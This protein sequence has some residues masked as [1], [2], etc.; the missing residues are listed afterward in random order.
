MR[1]LQPV[2]F[3][4]SCGIVGPAELPCHLRQDMMLHLLRLLSA[5]FLVT[6]CLK[7]PRTTYATPDR[8][9]L[10]VPNDIYGCA[11]PQ[12]VY[13]NTP[14]GQCVPYAY[15]GAAGSMYGF[16]TW[17]ECER[18]CG[19]RGGKMDTYTGK[20]SFVQSVPS[21]LVDSNYDSTYLLCPFLEI[22]AEHLQQ[23][24]ENI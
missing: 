20:F 21:F 24:S 13:Y 11:Y 7:W 17:E 14:Q 16:E 6:S 22:V 9:Q 4:C 23:R 1:L 12:R 5:L 19:M 15:C 10:P 2:F 8:C 18:V 3:L